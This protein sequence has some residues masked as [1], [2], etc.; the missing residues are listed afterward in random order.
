MSIRELRRFASVAAAAALVVCLAGL[1][2][3]ATITDDI[4]PQRNL[5]HVTL[6]NPDPSPDRGFVEVTVDLGGGKTASSVEPYAVGPSGTTVVTAVFESRVVE[7]LQ[8]L[9]IENPDPIP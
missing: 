4:D 6:V 1:V 7:V 2:T 9:I 3:H 8:A 5:V